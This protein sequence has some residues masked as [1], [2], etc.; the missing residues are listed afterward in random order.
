MRWAIPG[1]F[2]A[3]LA[4]VLPGCGYTL[5]HRL[6][7][8]FRDTRG[9]FVPVFDNTT[10]ETGAERVFT[11]ALIREIA[12]RGEIKI[13]SREEGAL[14]LRG[15]VASISYGATVLSDLGF[16]GLQSYRR[17]PLELGLTVNISL[18]LTDP[19]NGRVLWSSSFSGFRRVEAPLGR[20]YDFEAPSSVGLQTQSLA[21]SR[22][23]DVARD[24]MRDVY[25]E[26]VELF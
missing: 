25:D 19:A 17:L 13:A 16:K 3:A 23:A 18:R 26:M 11:N 8:V 5:S 10:E 2:A 12:S 24:I 22:Y 1:L 6:K 21:E 4:L 15:T 7:D 14:E 9:V 20:T